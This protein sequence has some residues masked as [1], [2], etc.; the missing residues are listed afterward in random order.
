ME[1]I[2]S[3]AQ[4]TSWLVTGRALFLLI[5][6]LGIACFS[7]IVARRLVPLIRGERDLRFDQPWVRSG[8]GSEILAG[9][10]EATTLSS[11]GNPAYFHFCGLPG[12]GH[13]R[14]FCAD[15]RRLREF[16]HAR[17]FGKSRPD[18]RHHHGLRRHHCFPLHGDR[19]HSPLGF[20][21]CAVRRA[22]KVRQSHTADA[23]FLLSLI[24]I[25]MVADSLF[26]AAK[27]AAQLPQANLL[28][29]WPHFRFRGC[30]RRLSS[31]LPCLLWGGFTSA[32]ISSM[33]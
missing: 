31:Q 19:G 3:A 30:C 15:C 14:F 10:V 9:S 5:H 23:I 13:S 28:K 27:A 29:C 1:G 8:K 33:N 26:A 17:P 16:R 20:Q 25:L 21:T 32:L 4:V 11:C 7:Y 6:L 24:A 2:Q 18:L 22:R 12:P